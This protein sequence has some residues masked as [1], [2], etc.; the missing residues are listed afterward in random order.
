M[1]LSVVI[2]G[3]ICLFNRANIRALQSV[4]VCVCDAYSCSA[5]GWRDATELRGV[6]AAV[7]YSS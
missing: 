1:Y 6:K 7:G 2:T 3:P 5:E 4:C